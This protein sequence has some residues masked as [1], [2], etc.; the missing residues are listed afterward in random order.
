MPI[1]SW[2]TRDL[3]QARIPYQVRHHAPAYT[4]RQLAERE[5]VSGHQVAKVVVALADWQPVLLVVP[6]T[7][8][9]D[10][11]K[12]S[13]SLGAFDLRIAEEAD[14]ARIF[15]DC[16]VGALPPLRHWPEIEVWVD[17]ALLEAHEIVFQAGTHE[18]AVC[19]DCE[20]WRRGVQPHVAPIGYLAA[21]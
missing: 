17:P 10:L 14:I 13:A 15:P 7:R 12:A 11:R 19:C 1:P 4:S 21:T 20:A 3:E 9:I 8:R 5:H 2:I 18:D 16:E 6:A